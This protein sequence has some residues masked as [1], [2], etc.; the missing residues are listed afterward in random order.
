MGT[1][2]LFGYYQ[3]DLLYGFFIGLPV[4]IGSILG[5]VA[6]C[7]ITFILIMIMGGGT[8]FLLGVVL[9][10]MLVQHPA[11]WIE[12]AVN[13]TY[14]NLHHGECEYILENTPSPPYMWR[15]DERRK[16]ALKEEVIYKNYYR[17]WVQIFPTIEDRD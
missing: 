16:K 11:N 3:F 5:I 4:I 7:I 6:L 9:F 17:C 15:D 2:T 14:T 13:K 1:I 12:S 8:G 10:L